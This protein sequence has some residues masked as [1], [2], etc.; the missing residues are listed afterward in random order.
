MTTPNTCAIVITAEQARGPAMA[1]VDPFDYVRRRFRDEYGV[2][3]DDPENDP[4]L[5]WERS[6]D[7]SAYRITFTATGTSEVLREAEKD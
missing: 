5:T 1:G 6:S 4:R 2:V 7:D 3:I